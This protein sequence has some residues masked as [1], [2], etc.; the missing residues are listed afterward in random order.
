MIT[1]NAQFRKQMYDDIGPKSW[2]LT[3]RCWQEFDPYGPTNLNINA[4]PGSPVDSFGLPTKPCLGGMRSNIFF[5]SWVLAT[6]F[7][8]Y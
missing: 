2:A 4:A 1:G 5:P 8:S 7:I 3:F 6:I